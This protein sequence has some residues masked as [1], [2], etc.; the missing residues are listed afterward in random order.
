MS[1]E[2]SLP[3]ICVLTAHIVT[4]LKLP[5]NDSQEPYHTLSTVRKFTLLFLR[6][7]PISFPISACLPFQLSACNGFLGNLIL[8][9]YN[10]MCGRILKLLEIGPK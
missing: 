1:L 7:L 2:Q 8:E 6:V 10:K 5:C 9:S 4:I 3:L